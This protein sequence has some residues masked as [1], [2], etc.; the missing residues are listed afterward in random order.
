MVITPAQIDLWR[1]VPTE[2]QNLEF[3]EAKNNY[4]FEKLCE[5]SVAIANERR[6]SSR[7]WCK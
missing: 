6:R 3:K 5:Y 2:T 7:S 4:A 1:Q